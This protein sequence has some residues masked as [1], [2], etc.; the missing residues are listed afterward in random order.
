MLL[1]IKKEQSDGDK[2]GYELTFVV[3]L[4]IACAIFCTL[5]FIWLC[6]FNF[7]GKKIEK[8]YEENEE[9]LKALLKP[10]VVSVVPEFSNRGKKASFEF[11]AKL[12][13]Q[14]LIF[15]EF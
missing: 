7:R 12:E 2:T 1:L 10:A 14:S 8:I 13:N 3:P 5:V 11:Y 6:S 9:H 15:D 4:V